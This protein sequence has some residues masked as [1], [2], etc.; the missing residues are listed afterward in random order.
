MPRFPDKTVLVTGAASGIGRATAL[1]FAREG[2]TVI[3][4]DIDADGGQETVRWIQEAGG[5]GVFLPADLS[6]RS[7][8]RKLFDE[9]FE[10]YGRLEIAVN[11]A[12][13]GG[14][15]TPTADYSDDAWD[16]VIALNQTGVFQCMKEELRHM[17]GKGGGAIVNVAS[18]AG[19]KAL[20]MAAAYVAS[21][22]AVLGL[23]KT[24]AVE[25]ARF[26]IRVNAICPVFTITPMVEKMFGIDPSLEKKLIRSIPLRRYGR[27]EEMAQAIL[28]LCDGTS[29]FVTG[30]CLP[31]DGGLMA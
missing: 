19:L 12:G 2:A 11:N 20:P 6:Q 3:V 16:K 13:T 27:P 14:I 29:E 31:M 24:A 1:A 10:R 9:I 21:K 7:E 30:L 18:I 26:G 17:Q 25:Y 28:W 22:H 15:M 8:V 23:T 4:A 5:Q